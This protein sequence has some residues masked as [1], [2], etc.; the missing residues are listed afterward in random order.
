MRNTLKIVGEYR[1]RYSPICI[2]GGDLRGE[3]AGYRY[4]FSGAPWR[5]LKLPAIR[6][7]SSVMASEFPSCR[8]QASRA[9]Y[10]KNAPAK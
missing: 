10:Y 9:A 8:P 5:W 1:K 4:R 2:E 7:N 6:K 3:H